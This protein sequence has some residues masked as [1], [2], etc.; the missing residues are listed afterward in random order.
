[1]IAAYLGFVRDVI[2]RTHNRHVV[3]RLAEETRFLKPLPSSRVPS[4]TIHRP[5][6]RRWSTI[7]VAGRTPVPVLTSPEDGYTL[8]PDDVR[9]ALTPRTA[10]V[11]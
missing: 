4:Y 2:E 6:V 5:K 9:R 7:R 8:S 3:D 11:G 10:A 1:M